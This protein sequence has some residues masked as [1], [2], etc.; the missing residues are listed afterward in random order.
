MPCVLPWSRHPWRCKQMS[1][2]GT[3]RAAGFTDVIERGLLVPRT[4]SC[5]HCFPYSSIILLG[6][7]CSG[8]DLASSGVVVG[9]RGQHTDSDDGPLSLRSIVIWRGSQTGT[10]AAGFTGFTGF[11]VECWCRQTS[12]CKDLWLVLTA[13]SPKGLA[14]TISSTSLT[15]RW[16]DGSTPASIWHLQEA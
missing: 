6:Q 1:S 10:C 13:G 9:R 15:N 2:A 11:I 8:K 16:L 5:K 4:G 12:S 3:L 7:W 14:G